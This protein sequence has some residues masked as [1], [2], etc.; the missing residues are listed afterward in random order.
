MLRKVYA[1]KLGRAENDKETIRFS[2]RDVPAPVFQLLEFDGLLTMS[3]DPRGSHSRED[4]VDGSTPDRRRIRT[5][6][7]IHHNR[8]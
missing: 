2:Q 7:A 1:Q 4:P 6:S 3:N 5:A 8:P